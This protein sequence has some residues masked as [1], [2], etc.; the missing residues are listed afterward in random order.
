MKILQRMAIAAVL[1]IMGT[2]ATAQE[3]VKHIVIPESELEFKANDDFTEVAITKFIGEIK[4]YDGAVMEIPAAIQGITVT[5]IGQE[6]FMPEYNRNSH[7]AICL[8]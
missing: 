3:N 6:A 2:L 5:K 8:L 4:N 1:V 7:V